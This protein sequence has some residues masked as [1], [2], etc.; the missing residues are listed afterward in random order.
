LIELA[1]RHLTSVTAA[2]KVKGPNLD[3]EYYPCH[4]HG[5]DCTWCFCPFYPCDDPQ[6]GGEWVVSAYEGK[7]WS[8]SRCN[9]I[10]RPEVASEILKEIFQLVSESR[11][12]D[13]NEIPREKLLKIHFQIKLSHPPQ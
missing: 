11:F 7:V 8:C 9:W 5:Q 12:N 6:T 3:C 13:F 4:F 10:H 2:G 1:E